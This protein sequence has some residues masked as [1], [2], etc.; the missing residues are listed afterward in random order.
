MSTVLIL[1]SG[2]NALDAAQWPRSTFDEIVVINNAW[3]VRDDWSYL[4][5]PDDFPPERR[6]GGMRRDQRIITSDIYV[7]AQNAFG[8]F[9]LAGGTM[10]FTA[11][12][13]A[14]HALRPSVAAFFGCDMVYPSD[15]R[16]HFYGTGTADPLRKDVTL[17]SLEAKSCRLR[18]F[19]AR[20]DCALVNLSSGESRLSIPKVTVGELTSAPPKPPKLN[21]EKWDRL[22]AQEERLG[23]YVDSGRYWECEH[24][25]DPV[26]IDGIDR[27]WRTFF[28]DEPQPAAGYADR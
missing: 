13:W 7:P 16:T 4:I 6:P 3:R 15:A 14:L 8:G 25:F 11:A 20:Q 24:L 1:G 21:R 17:R 26:K 12:Y 2:P 10:S 19:A 22:I 27:Q 5:H 23:Y 18:A 28:N 9:V